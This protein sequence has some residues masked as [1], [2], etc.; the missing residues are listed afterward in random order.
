VIH[1]R[2]TSWACEA[3]HWDWRARPQPLPDQSTMSRRMRNKAGKRFYAFLDKVSQV[4]STSPEGASVLTSL[5]FLDGKA[6]SVAMHSTDPDAKFGRGTGQ[7]SKGY[8]LH[9]IRTNKPM[10]DQWAVTPLNVDERA[11]A[12]RLIKRIEGAGYVLADAM[13]DAADLHIRSADVNHQLVCPRGK[14][15]RG[16]GHRRQSPHRLRSIALLE[17]P[18]LNPFG[19]S[20]HAQ[21]RQIE[22]SIGHMVSFGGGL[23]CLPAWV[24]RI[25]RVRGWVYGKLLINAVRIRRLRDGRA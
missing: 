22:Q 20:L 8:K 7:K 19:P 24:R 14:P 12:R 17:G 21:R 3:E 10:P 25:W 16:L 23:Q 6:L 2:P 13:Y 15:G 9:L 18:A 1:D 11:V 4:L 5:K